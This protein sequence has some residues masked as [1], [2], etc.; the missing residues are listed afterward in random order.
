MADAI[1][2]LQRSPRTSNQDYSSREVAFC[3]TSRAFETLTDDPK[4]HIEYMSYRSKAH[5]TNKC[6]MEIA[7]LVSLLGGNR[8]TVLAQNSLKQCSHS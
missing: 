4:L 1:N 8:A 5:A 2:V 3:P 7:N 6:P